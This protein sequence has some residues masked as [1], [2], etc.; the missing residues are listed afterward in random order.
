MSRKKEEMQRLRKHLRNTHGKELP[1][2]TV[3]WTT[4]AVI[5]IFI[6]ILSVVLITR[7]SLTGKVIQRWV[8]PTIPFSKDPLACRNVPACGGEQSYMCCARGYVPGFGNQ[9]CT[10]PLYMLKSEAPR[11]PEQMPYACSCPEKYQ[12]RQSWPIPFS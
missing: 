12:Y 4:V 5:G 8:D 7:Y 3:F 11:C 2:N 10:A 1:D 9:R 6:V